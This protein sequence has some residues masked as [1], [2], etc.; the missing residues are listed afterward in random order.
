ME[1]RILI[2]ISFMA[3]ISIIHGIF[4]VFSRKYYV[5][6]TSYVWKRKNETNK[7]SGE[8]QNRW[9]R[10]VTSLLLGVILVWFLISVLI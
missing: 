2:A 5:W 3:T 4:L 8:F 10:A 9:V 1:N 6:F 7:E